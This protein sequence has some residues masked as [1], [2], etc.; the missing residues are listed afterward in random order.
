M[1]NKVLL[2]LVAVFLFGCGSKRKIAEFKKQEVHTVHELEEVVADSTKT[3][4]KDSS[5]TVTNIKEVW[6]ETVKEVTIF[7]TLGRITSTTKE[8]NRKGTRDT[9]KQEIKGNQSDST[10]V[11]KEVLKKVID[12]MVTSVDK[13]S[14]AIPEKKRNPIWHWIG[15]ALFICIL[16]FFVWKVVLKR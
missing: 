9:D 12:S 1:R 5:K 7:D 15:G 14:E 4:K 8:T 2:L 16:L 13:R 11:R 10:N 3:T 6:E